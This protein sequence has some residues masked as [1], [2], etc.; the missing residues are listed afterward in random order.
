[1]QAVNATCPKG[2]PYPENLRPG[3]SDCKVCHRESQLRRYYLD[4]EKSKAAASKWQKDNR[5]RRR[6]YMAGYRER[7][8]EYFRAYFRN[9]QRWRRVGKDDES[10]AYVQILLGD[11]CSYCGE[12]ADSIDHIV[13]TTKGGTSE[14]DNLTA[15]CMSCNATK[16][17]RTL[18]LHLDRLTR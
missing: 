17:N 16:H 7:N 14:W 6:A 3:R 15:A 5:E 2:H 8:R 1:M 12:S 13:P 11:P 4:P 9:Q 18:L 10:L